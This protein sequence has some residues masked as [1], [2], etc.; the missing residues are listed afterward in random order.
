MGPY[1]HA[2]ATFEAQRKEQRGK[3]VVPFSSGMKELDAMRRHY[4]L[5]SLWSSLHDSLERVGG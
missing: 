4:V 1:L 2:L 3:V 5:I